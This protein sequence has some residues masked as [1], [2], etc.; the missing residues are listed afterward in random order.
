[1]GVLMPQER[2]AVGV[3]VVDEKLGL[4]FRHVHGGGALGFA[5]LAAQ[6]EVHDLIH[7][8][9]KE[10]VGGDAPGEDVAQRVG[11]G[12]GGLALVL[13]SH[14]AGAH[15]ADVQLAADA[16][17]VAHFDGS[18]IAAVGVPVEDRL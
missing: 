11:A 8:M 4:D 5:R 7:L 12:A 17:A 15:R 3:E 6:A 10:L 18:G 1:M 13:R 2:R 9:R 14:E 16:G